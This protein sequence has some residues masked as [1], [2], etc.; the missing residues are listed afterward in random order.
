M[1]KHLS[2]E[3]VGLLLDATFRIIDSAKKAND[4]NNV[5]AE[6]Q[7][8]SL[9]VETL[10]SRTLSDKVNA[11][12]SKREHAKNLENNFTRVRYSI[13]ESVATGFQEAMSRFA[14][15]PVDFYCTVTAVQEPK[16]AVSH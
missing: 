11:G 16:T 6:I 9:F 7:F 15:Q 5:Q 13:Q 1:K 8:I 12:K 3:E 14:K 10:I 4:S 2:F